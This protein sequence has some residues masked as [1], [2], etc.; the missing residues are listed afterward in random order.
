MPSVRRRGDLKRF[1]L[2][3]GNRRAV[4]V[5]GCMHHEYFFFGA[6]AVDGAVVAHTYEETSAISVGESRDAACQLRRIVYL[7]LEVLL[8]VLALRNHALEASGRFSRR[9]H[10]CRVVSSAAPGS[11]IIHVFLL[12]VC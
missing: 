11:S 8:L 2:N 9:C 7:V 1:E 10:V 3:D 6:H 5:G 4:F 12:E